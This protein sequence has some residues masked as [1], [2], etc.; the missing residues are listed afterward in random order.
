MG[1]IKKV[2][3]AIRI[4]P[5]YLTARGIWGDLCE[6]IHLHYR[7]LRLDFSVKEWAAFCSAIN[8]IQKGI[9]FSIEDKKYREGDPNFLLQVQY[10]VPL[11]SD[12]NYYPNRSLIEIQQD[13]TVHFH[14]RDIRLHWTSDEFE[15]I[16]GQ[17]AEALIKY[18]KDWEILKF[19][20]HSVKVPTRYWLIMDVVQP[21]DEGHRPLAIDEEH[22]EGIEYVKQLILSGKTI[23]PILVDTRGQRMDGFKRYMAAKELG[24]KQIECI[25]DPNARMG[26]QHNQGFLDDEG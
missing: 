7:N 13:N 3:S 9:E 23:R 12:S 22:R 19:I 11:D 24:H 20:H 2:L 8:S 21:Y 15:V 14:Y 25:V 6:N 5:R 26:G 18:K 16:A 1:A 17:F 4:S 10:N